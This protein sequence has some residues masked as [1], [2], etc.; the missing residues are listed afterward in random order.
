MRFKSSRPEPDPPR[1]RLVAEAANESDGDILDCGADVA[2]VHLLADGELDDRAA[3]GVRAHIA[4]CGD[5]RR[6]WDA[7]VKVRRLLVAATLAKSLPA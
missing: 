2:D 5:C 4:G 7:T 1:L 6:Q 3:A